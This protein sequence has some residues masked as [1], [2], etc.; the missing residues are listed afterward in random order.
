MNC[1]AKQSDQPSV[2]LTEIRDLPLR[3]MCIALPSKL[4]STKKNNVSQG[5]VV[6]HVSVITIFRNSTT[7]YTIAF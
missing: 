1:K 3:F 2:N 6:N 5:V 4:F 7:D